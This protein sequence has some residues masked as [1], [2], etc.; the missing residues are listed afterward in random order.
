MNVRD[1]ADLYYEGWTAKKG[2]LSA[3]PLADD[4]VFQSP[5]AWIESAE[6]YRTMAVEAGKAIT[7]FDVRHL[8]VD[9]DIVCAILDWQMP[10]L[11]AALTA[12][13]LLTVKDSRIVSSEL[14]YDAQ[15][16]RTAGAT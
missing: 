9:G 8:F 12:A 3:V 7:R 13:E 1:I 11:N 10:P 14:V 2:D 6:A 5:V 4:F 15:E 16:L